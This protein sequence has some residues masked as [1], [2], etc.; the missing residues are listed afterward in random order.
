[1]EDFAEE[2][3]GAAGDGLAL[4]SAGIGLTVFAAAG[5][6]FPLTEAGVVFAI[7]GAVLIGAEVTDETELFADGG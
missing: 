5:L 2:V 7:L 1:M 6:V 3:G 4:L